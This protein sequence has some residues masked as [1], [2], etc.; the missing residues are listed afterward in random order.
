MTRKQIKKKLANVSLA[1][2]LTTFIT[3]AAGCK[4]IINGD[5]H[6][7]DEYSKLIS[8]EMENG[9]KINMSPDF[10]KADV[11]Y[12]ISKK[13]NLKS[14]SKSTGLSEKEL[15]KSNSAFTTKQGIK[16]LDGTTLTLYKENPDDYIYY[17]ASE[18]EQLE[19]VA[20]KLETTT[21]SLMQENNLSTTK[22]RKNQVIKKEQTLSQRKDIINDLKDE[23]GV[24]D[25]SRKI[26][27]SKD[28]TEE[29]E[30]SIHF[31]STFGTY[32]GIDI[33]EHNGE[34]DFEKV[35]KDKIDFAIIRMFDCWYM[36]YQNNTVSQLDAKF[37]RNIRACEE[38]NLP[39]GI[40]V[41]SRAT[42]E[43]MAKQEARKF[44]EYAK[45][46]KIKPTW[47]IY[48]DI[49]SQESQPLY[50]ESN[51][52]VN[53]PSFI[54]NN[55][56]QIIKNFKAWASVLEEEGYCCGIYTGDNILQ[57][58]DKDG[59]KLANYEVWGARYKYYN[60]NCDFEAFDYSEPGYKGDLGM[61]QF[62]SSGSISGIN[63]RVDCNVC[64]YK[65]DTG[66]RLKNKEITEKEK[67]KILSKKN[68]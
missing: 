24:Y 53:S 1:F 46:Y 66:I 9:S 16:S 56:D 12:T 67:I 33:S 18:D 29:D 39:Y 64:K 17:I 44:L 6:D 3:G 58:I 61:F 20:K 49:E 65:Y 10:L 15:I 34:I 50:T 54:S 37:E 23:K 60:Q 40:Y 42:N 7:K 36:N 59:D 57:I 25:F 19:D 13:D 28:D 31:D 11:K 26:T 22:L 35:K 45:K 43:E 55:P 41:Y 48:C 38:V 5:A 2:L 8:L 32:T 62:S 14:I 27:L 47:P 4:T 30:A 68:N 52:I 51:Q 63:G 21:K